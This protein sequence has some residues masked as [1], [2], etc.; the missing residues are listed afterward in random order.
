LRS[1]HVEELAEVERWFDV[2]APPKPQMF[3][4]PTCEVSLGVAGAPARN[5]SRGH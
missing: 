4:I 5:L 3:A 1:I 2:C